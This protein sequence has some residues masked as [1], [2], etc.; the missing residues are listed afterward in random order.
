MAS[1]QGERGTRHERG[2]GHQWTKRRNAVMIRDDYLCQTCQRNGRDTAAQEVDHINPKS[3][4][5]G[6]ELSNLEAI[7]KPCHA[8]K[9]AAEGVE[10]RGGAKVTQYDAK[11]FPIWK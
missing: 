2:Y 7:C 6:D 5:G 3:Q 9:T 10:A 11:G 1:W 8:V 4:D